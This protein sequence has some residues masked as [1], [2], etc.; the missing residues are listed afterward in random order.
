M[1]GPR[2]GHAG[3][4][5]KPSKLRLYGE[6]GDGPRRSS[7]AGLHQACPP[8]L[9]RR[10][11]GW[12]V[13]SVRSSAILGTFAGCLRVRWQLPRPSRLR[14]LPG[15]PRSGRSSGGCPLLRFLALSVSGAPVRRSEPEALR[16]GS[17]QGRAST[18][19]CAIMF[20]ILVS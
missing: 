2:S 16:S 4:Y 7:D 9:N 12:I 11:R 1:D 18:Q 20:R 13:G 6:P 19:M 15:I 10:L 3:L 5:L 14:A 8:E 17:G